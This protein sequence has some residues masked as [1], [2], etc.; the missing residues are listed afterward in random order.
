M[1]AKKPPNGTDHLDHIDQKREPMIDGV[2]GVANEVEEPGAVNCGS[3]PQLSEFTASVD[4]GGKPC[5]G[6]KAK[7][8]SGTTGAHIPNPG[9]E[10]KRGTHH[11]SSASPETSRMKTFDNGPAVQ[12]PE[13]RA[14]SEDAGRG[15]ASA[16][17]PGR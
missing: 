13:I 5:C 12:D 14:L 9:Q 2:V 1:Q 3:P 15:E 7:Q 4:A 10:G 17:A 16:T 11:L 8:A 6:E